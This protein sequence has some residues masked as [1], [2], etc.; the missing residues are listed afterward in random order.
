MFSYPPPLIKIRY[1]PGNVYYLDGLQNYGL[2]RMF[3]VNFA[4]SQQLGGISY[5]ESRGVCEDDRKKL[6]K[7]LGPQNKV[8]LW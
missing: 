5:H 1:S 8:I 4:S 7:D 3:S 2:T 6:A